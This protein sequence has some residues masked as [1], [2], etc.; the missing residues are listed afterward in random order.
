MPV[1]PS[2]DY[3]EVAGRYDRSR[4]AE[5]AIATALADGL[6]TLDA[7]VVLEIG[8]GTGNYTGVLCAHGFSMLAIDREPA[9]VAIGAA[10]A[11]VS[12]IVAD[13]LHFPIASQ[14]VDAVTGVNI[15]HH[16]TDLEAAL[17]ELRRVS[18]YGIAVQAVVR[19]NLAA[20][21]YR[22][23]FPEIDAALLPLHPTLGAL[24]VGLLRHGFSQVSTKNVV[25][26]GR[27]DLTFEAARTRPNLLFDAGFRDSTSGFRRL[28]PLAVAR[29]LADL[30]SDL[31][32]GAFAEVASRYD[33]AWVAA[34]DC[35]VIVAS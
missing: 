14:S 11:P 15:L 5:D 18:R 21:W 25:Y 26:S 1:F 27:C 31:R 28:T 19:E 3:S 29:G 16:L 2:I 23:Y 22:N 32:S 6:H 12:W 20:L 13:A 35:V 33:A 8:A 7:R 10:K 34:G 17:S 24:I 30:E 9:M 4:S